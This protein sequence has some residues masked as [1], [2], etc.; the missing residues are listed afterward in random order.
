MNEEFTTIAKNM[1]QWFARN[2]YMGNDPFQVD[3]KVFGGINKLGF[4]KYI[5]KVLKPFHSYIPGSTFTKYPHIYHPKAVGLI[6]GGNSNIYKI[7][8]DEEL[9]NES[10]KLL[11]LLDELRSPGYKFYCWGHPFEWG[12]TPR[13]PKNTP[14]VCVTSPICHCLLDFHEIS[15]N[16]KTLEMCVSAA[17]GLLKENG[18]D[19][20]GEHMLSLYYSPL[21][22]KYVY[23]SDI[24][25]ASFLYRLNQIQPNIEYIEFADKLINFVVS[26]QNRDGSWIY[27][28]S[29]GDQS[30]FTIDNR[31]TSFV[32]EAFKIINDIRSDDSLTGIIE[33]GGNYYFKNLFE[34]SIP[35]WSPNKT[36]PVDIH[37]IANA[38]ITLT[39][40]NEIEKA[41][42]TLQFALA[43]MFNGQDQFYYKLFANGRVNKT[44]FIRWGQ[45]WMYQAISSLI[46]FSLYGKI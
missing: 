5:R 20:L 33:K 28:E 42:S 3:E 25:A 13:Y 35:K 44:V 16:Q 39:K 40:L 46:K 23:N 14:F 37:D 22:K 29:K 18:F 26:G 27:A 31:H 2:H 24:M 32:L 43:K 21:D 12:Q 36:Y 11:N 19:V 9:I 38:I 30:I 15:N 17:N 6:I 45:A 8:K 41:R 4:A 34:G 1:N 10:D 7:T